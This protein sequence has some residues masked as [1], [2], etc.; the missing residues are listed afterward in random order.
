MKIPNRQKLF[1]AAA[2]VRPINNPGTANVNAC[3]NIK[4]IKLFVLNPR[5]LSMPNSYVFPS[6]SVNI[7]EYISYADKRPR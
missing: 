3:I 6:T 7:N 1:K 4:V 2:K 5:A